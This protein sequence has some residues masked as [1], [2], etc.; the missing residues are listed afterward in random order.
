MRV[1]VELI[2]EN[3]WTNHSS[4]SRTPLRSGNINPSPGCLPTRH[5]LTA[6]LVLGL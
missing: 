2:R 1:R 5:P 3:A 6:Y 4:T